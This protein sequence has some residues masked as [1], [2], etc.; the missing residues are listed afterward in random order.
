MKPHSAKE[1]R[2][3]ATIIAPDGTTVLAGPVGANVQDLA[4]QTRAQAQLEAPETTHMI[5]MRGPDTVTLTNSGYVQVDGVLYIVDYTRDP[6]I[7]RPG[8]WLEV[9]CHVERTAS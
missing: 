9:F 6:S 1:L 7:P 2:Y 3:W 5:L 4:G 8:M